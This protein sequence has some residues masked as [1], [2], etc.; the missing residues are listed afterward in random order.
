[1]GQQVE[2]PAYIK[3]DTYMQVDYPRTK[4]NVCYISATE[5]RRLRAHI[6]LARR[7]AE[8]IVSQKGASENAN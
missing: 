4:I 1:M 8:D 5:S 2:I 6:N 7:F 3:P